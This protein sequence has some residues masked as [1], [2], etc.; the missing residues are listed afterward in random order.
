MPIVL[1]TIRGAPQTIGIRKYLFLMGH[2]LFGSRNSRNGTSR[3]QAQAQFLIPKLLHAGFSV[4]D[5]RHI[6]TSHLYTYV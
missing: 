4:R 5:L 6:Y 1:R 3:T 2:A